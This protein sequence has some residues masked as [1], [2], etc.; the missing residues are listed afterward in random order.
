MT[1]KPTGRDKSQTRDIVALFFI[2]SRT[3]RILHEGF[4]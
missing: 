2:D 1:W 3:S 4:E